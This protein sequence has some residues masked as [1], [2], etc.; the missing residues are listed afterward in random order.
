MRLRRSVWSVSFPAVLGEF[1]RIRFQA[2]SA[3]SDSANLP[4]DEAGE[5]P[6]LAWGDFHARLRFTRS[7]IPKQKW[8]LLVV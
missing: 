8:G 6:F 7:T 3:N 1:G 5:S 2:F 4:G